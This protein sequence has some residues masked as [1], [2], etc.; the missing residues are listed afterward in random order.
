M[1]VH[2]LM[3]YLLLQGTAVDER[4]VNAIVVGTPKE[5]EDFLSNE[6]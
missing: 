4:I 6:N 5:Y 2:R 3:K 1:K